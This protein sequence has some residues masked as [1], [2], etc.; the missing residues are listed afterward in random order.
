MQLDA[1]VSRCREGVD[2][3]DV[4]VRVFSLTTTC[5]SGPAVAER[6][7]TVRRQVSCGGKITQ[8]KSALAPVEALQRCGSRLGRETALRDVSPTSPCDGE[9]A[10]R[11]R[12]HQRCSRGGD[13]RTTLN[14]GVVGPVRRVG[15]RVQEGTA[16]STLST[17]HHKSATKS[18]LNIGDV[19][20]RRQETSR[21]RVQVVE[22]LVGDR[23]VAQV[24]DSCHLLPSSFGEE[25]VLQTPGSRPISEPRKLRL[26]LRRTE[27]ALP[28]R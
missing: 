18:F 8:K 19:V 26:E 2:I 21:A 23:L 6:Q 3:V 11:P 4:D 20:V 16:A 10:R 1:N 28:V 7:R 22:P 24:F 17:S 13:R 25:C 15:P 9:A 5:E 12:C 14:S 27:S